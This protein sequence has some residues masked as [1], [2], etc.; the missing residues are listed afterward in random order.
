MSDKQEPADETWIT[1]AG[2]R[3]LVGD[4]TEDHAKNIL[5]M[6]LKDER[7]RRDFFENEMV[8][9]IESLM[10]QLASDSGADVTVSFHKFSD[11]DELLGG[12]PQV[13]E[14]MSEIDNMFNRHGAATPKTKH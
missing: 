6:I 9:K 7:Q 1:E 14:Q 13:E 2:E 11:L 4:L 5:R 3:I 12:G 10:E 8:P